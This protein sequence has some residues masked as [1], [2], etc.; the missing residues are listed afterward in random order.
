ML[1]RRARRPR[2]SGPLCPGAPP[3]APG[4]WSGSAARGGRL[5][6]SCPG[7]AGPRARASP[8]A[9]SP[10]TC[11]RS[12]GS[13]WRT[14]HVC[15]SAPAAPAGAT[16]ARPAAPTRARAPASPPPALPRPP[17]LRRPRRREALDDPGR[18]V[19][20]PPGDGALGAELQRE[21]VQ[22]GGVQGLGVVPRARVRG[23]R[24]RDGGAEGQVP[25]L[26]AAARAAV[27][28]LVEQP[29]EDVQ[30]LAGRA[31]DV[32]EDA[33]FGGEDAP[34]PREA[35]HQLPALRMGLSDDDR[36]AN[37]LVELGVAVH[38]VEE[39]GLP[40]GVSGRLREHGLGDA[41]RTLD[42]HVLAGDERQE[43]GLFLLGVP[44][45]P[46][47]QRLPHPRQGRG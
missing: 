45:D 20:A 9:P 40:R 7:P 5:V 6:R 26:P 24:R 36:V 39:E 11:G 37:Q 14:A 17:P 32:V 18:L 35:A 22:V 29:Q 31:R 21:A 23:V 12:A 41:G 15:W 10:G 43:D 8:A 1:R 34:W 28:A 42:V 25:G 16:A 46:L 13:F 47:V 30:G 38:L 4:R 27:L 44:D 2:R 33:E 3:R 19:P